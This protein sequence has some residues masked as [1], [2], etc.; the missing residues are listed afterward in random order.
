MVLN[1]LKLN[2]LNSIK[3]FLIGRS[4]TVVLDGEFSNAVPVTSGIAQWSALGPR[5]FLLYINDLPDNI[6]SQ[7]WLFADDTA[8]Y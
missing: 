4:Q 5:L 1:T 8:V 2:T 3:S 6:Q 7:F